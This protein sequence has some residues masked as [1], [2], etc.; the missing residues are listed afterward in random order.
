MGLA[1]ALSTALTGLQ[2]A[3][4]QIDVVGNNL[5]NSQT[6]G[7]KASSAVFATQLLQTQGLGSA[8]TGG[9]GGTNP[10]QIGLGV[11]VAEITPDFTQGT[12]EISSNPTDLAIQGDGMFIVQGNTGERLYSRNGI[13]KT[14]SQ[15]ELVT[16]TGN[17]LLG[18][19][20]DDKF[21]I[22]QTSLV[23]LTIPLGA[24]AVAAATQNVFMEGTLSPIGDVADTAEVIQSS[25]LGDGSVPRPDSSSVTLSAI[26][27]AVGPGLTGNYSY[28]ITMFDSAGF[29]PETRPSELIGPISVTSSD[30]Q[31][32]GFPPLV[33]GYDRI[34]IYRNLATDAGT[35]YQIST[36]DPAVTPIYVD[37]T[38]D[39]TAGG[40]PVVNMDGPQINTNTLLTDVLKRDGFNYEQLFQ[41]GTLSFEGKKG[42]RTLA[43]KDFTVTATSTVQELID[44]IE[45]SL[46]IQDSLDDP[47]NPIPG[48]VN[49]IPGETTPHA[50]GGSIFN[51]RIRIVGNNGVDNALG[52]GISA[53]TV[54]TPTGGIS[55]P[56]LGFGSVQSAVGESAVSDFVVY[57]SLG[58]P[59]NV[60]I[61]AVLEQV[62]G[63]ATTFRWFADS[64]ENDPLN[65]SDISVGTGL[66]T[67]DGEGKLIATTNSTVSIERRNIPSSTPLEFDLDFSKVTG[68]AVANSSIAAARQDGSGAGTLTRFTIGEE[69]II[70]GIFTNGITRDLGQIRLARFAN[71]AGLEQ[72]GQNLFAEGVNSGLPVEGNPGQQGVGSLV[73][74]ALE[75]SNTDIGANLIDLVLATTQYRGNTRV[76]TAAQQLLDEL[77]NLRR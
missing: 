15:N 41:I 35:F 36:I 26:P 77:L 51:S 53:F 70:R 64:P 37:N 43:E 3:E 75:L 52:I 29:Q 20:I 7:F 68:F 72:R 66:I 25:I 58:V 40:N 45:D 56:N 28:L 46:G 54:K 34:R 67:F 47:Q 49:N 76:I 2:A 74:G 31:L 24:A 9:D 59:M 73:A 23:P 1:S 33:P 55:T 8:P 65:G 12:I 13:F 11:Q 38:D 32:S 57:D 60:R 14:N 71:P 22:Q 10:R 62:T 17:R 19:G 63:A 18:F 30:I 61:T 16:V 69:G 6:V 21:A 44:F 48:S 50:P 4:T 5:A 27:P 39:A 42:G